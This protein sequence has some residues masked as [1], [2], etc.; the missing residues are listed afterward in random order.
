ML[1]LWGAQIFFAARGLDYDGEIYPVVWIA[2]FAALSFNTSFIFCETV[3]LLLLPGRCLPE[4]RSAEGK[5]AVLW[6]LKDE[7]DGLVERITYS[8]TG[9][10]R[11]NIE[12]WILSDSDP[13]GE[14][15][16]QE[17]VEKVARKTGVPINY[18]RRDQRKERKQGN[19]KEW[20]AGRRGKY[21]YLF[22]CDADS[23]IPPDAVQKLLRKAEYPG[24]RD[25]A[26]FQAAIHITH[27]KTLFAEMQRTGQSIAQ[28]LYFPAQQKV[29]GKSIS[30]GHNCLVRAGDL[31][32]TKIPEGIMSHDIWETALLDRAGKRTVFC[33]DVVT[34]DEAPANYLEL[35]RRDRRWAKGTL[36]A[37]PLIF[38]KGISFESRFLAFYSIYLYLCQPLLLAWMLAGFIAEAVYEKPLFASTVYPGSVFVFSL[39]VICLHKFAVAKSLR[40]GSLIVKEIAFSTLISLN[41]VLY[42]SVDIISLLFER[43]L[44]WRPMA[45]DPF[46]RITWG[47]CAETLWG[48]CLFG[49]ALFYL[50]AK[51]APSSLI[52][53]FPFLMSFVLSIPCVYWTG[54]VSVRRDEG[55]G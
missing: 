11:S 9:N 42:Q 28:K 22:V 18:R 1:G 48:G 15:R 55:G 52:L 43:H 47:E 41:N 36:Q 16:E 25:I 24:N 30:F 17:M 31:Y 21:E 5:T 4:A 46:A 29:F 13:D 40:D 32:R 50:G 38:L 34:F 8:V 12:F 7:K 14:G 35:R 39:G 3:F 23:I 54:R 51:G 33:E 2:G 20:L 53:T 26:I 45:K 37:W 49:A 19:I 6:C 10:S 44:C 27:A